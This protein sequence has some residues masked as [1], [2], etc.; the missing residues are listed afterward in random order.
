MDKRKFLEQSRRLD[1]LVSSFEANVR[2]TD[3]A[4]EFFEEQEW[5]EAYQADKLIE[6][7]KWVLDYV[8]KNINECQREVLRK[9]L[10]DAQ[11]TTFHN[12]AERFRIAVEARSAPLK[13]GS[14][15]SRLQTKPR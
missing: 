2:L 8:A 13:V 3:L 10:P 9:S 14:S 5:A 15:A 12:Y 7:L 11:A 4:L 1:V 6:R